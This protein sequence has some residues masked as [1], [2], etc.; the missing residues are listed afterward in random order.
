MVND[1]TA[2]LNT[3]FTVSVDA[4][5]RHG[6]TTGIS[7]HDRATTIRKLI[8]PETTASDLTRPGHVFPLR[9]ASG[10]VLRRAG[11]TEAAVDLAR[12]AGLAPAGVI[13]EILNHDGSMARV[14]DLVPLAHQHGLKIITIKD[15][16]E[17]R[18][19]SEKLVR[20]TAS[21]VIPTEFGKFSLIAYETSVDSRLPGGPMS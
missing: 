11:H 3:A 13:C 6:V 20:R 18:L 8:K 4:H 2:P 10:G 14:P 16:I 21:T 15:L 19:K 5:T 12:L 17:F 9:A 1:N 7:A